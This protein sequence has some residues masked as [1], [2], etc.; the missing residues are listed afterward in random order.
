MW[1]RA[2]LLAL[3]GISAIAVRC[4][5]LDAPFYDQ[6]S[7]RQCDV[8][9][10]ARNYS[11]NGYRFAY[12]QIDWAGDQPGFVGT[13][14]PI[15]P[16]TVAIAYRFLGVHEWI[17]RVQTLLFFAASLPLFFGIARRA[18]D[19]TAAIFA[20]IF[21]ALAPVMIAAG[22]AFMPDVPSL[23][24][25]LAGWYYFQKWCDEKVASPES[26]SP[27]RSQNLNLMVSSLAIA[28]AVLIKPTTATIAAPLFALAYQC[29]GIAGWRRIELWMAAVVALFPSA[30]W[31][32]H[33]N[34]IAHL[35]YPYH[36]FGAG[37]VRVMPLAWYWRLLIQ[38]FTSTLTP[39]VFLIGVFGL[40]ISRRSQRAAPF[41]WWGFAMFLFIFLVGYGNRH[42][43]Y[44]LPLV[45]IMAAFAGAAASFLGN[46]K[47]LPGVAITIC[48][49]GFA[50]FYTP[51]FFES[52]ALSLWRLGLELNRS[53][54][55]GALVIAADDG[56]PT[57]FYYA[58]RKGWHFLEREGLYD[59]NPR[60]SA[61]II[62]D[63]KSLRDRGATHLV[64]YNGTM[65]WLNYFPEF[66]DNLTGSSSFMSKSV[67]YR[68]YELKSEQ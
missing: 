13:E 8:A 16:F 3:I 11:E 42:Q 35:F 46:G 30:I 4:W 48:F 25:A 14:F 65:W 17:G 1:R 61:Q 56:D 68:I 44:Q 10:I 43:W 36:F 66:V 23:T 41:R 33:A 19:E 7:W 31:Y 67:D 39:I 64:F 53:T 49:G 55:P 26:Y 60:D 24:F 38:T 51:R 21:Y 45:P 54:P 63:L 52:S 47:R 9:A 18:F 50:A 59:G 57:A 58:H 20:L 15:L 12:P 22:R 28:L 37:G 62:A 32:W 5:K 6:W 27:S 34:R 40:G 2:I 29:F